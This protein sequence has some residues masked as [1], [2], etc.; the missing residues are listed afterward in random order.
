MRGFHV[1][2][3]CKPQSRF[4]WR[5][6]ARC[7]WLP[8]LS[9]CRSVGP[10]PVPWRS[11]SPHCGPSATHV[12]PP[13]SCHHISSLH[14]CV[15]YSLLQCPARLSHVY[16]PTVSA[17]D[18][19]YHSFLQLVRC[20]AIHPDQV[21]PQSASRLKTA[22]ILSGRQACSI[23]SLTPEETTTSSPPRPGLQS[24]EA[25]GL[26]DVLEVSPLLMLGG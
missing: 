14:T 19:I 11:P 18:L 13:H 4:M 16:R 23:R 17:G 6:A 5:P 2:L 15:R 26:E 21:L 25:V 10:A 12:P 20:L 9:S 22:L 8:L 1:G 3:M 24:G 7:E